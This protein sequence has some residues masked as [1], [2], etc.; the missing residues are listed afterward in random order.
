MNKLISLRQI[1][2][3]SKIGILDKIN[4]V[5]TKIDPADYLKTFNNNRILKQFLN[6]NLFPKNLNNIKIDRQ[7][8]FTD[9]F[10]SEFQW[11]TTKIL[12][13]IQDINK[14]SE[15]KDSFEL[16][17][18]KN[19]YK[20]ATK[21]N[22]EIVNT[23]G[24][25]LWSIE[26]ELHVA[27][28][29]I[30]P[31]ENWRKLSDYLKNIKNPFYEFCINASSK[32]IENSISFESFVN[33]I[34]NDINTINAD[35]L[36]K[37]FFVFNNFKL[38][39][40]NYAFS[41]LR[42]VLYMSNLFSLIDQYNILID[43]I[44]FNIGSKDIKYDNL[45]NSFAND[46]I[47]KGNF[48]SRVINIKN[49]LSKSDFKEN[50]NL[51]E[52]NLILEN[53]YD[54][55]FDSSLNQ[56]R[57]FIA[58][59]PLEFEIYEVYVKS[60]LNL[61]KD[62]ETVFS[63]STESIL[64]ELYHFLKFEKDNEKH[65]KKLIKFALKYS[66]STFG[67]QIMDF[68]SIV[69]NN[70]VESIRYAFYSNSYKI[71]LEKQVS[72]FSEKVDLFFSKFNY[73]SYKKILYGVKNDEYKKF[74]SKDELLKINAEVTY[75]YDN[76]NYNE[77]IKIIIDNYSSCIS[78]NYYKERFIYFLLN[79]YIKENNIEEALNLFGTIIFDETIFYV[80][81]N[82]KE[83]YEKTFKEDDKFYYIKN[84][85]SLILASLYKSEYNLYE[86][87]DEFLCWQDY[88]IKD[89]INIDFLKEDVL[90]YLL[91]KIC[92]IDTIKYYFAR[93]NDAEEFRLKILN[94]L[95]IFDEKDKKSYSAEIDQINKKI[96][97]RNVIKEV[98]NGRLFVDVD[99]LKEQLTEKYNDDFNRLLRIVGERKNN[100]L[101]G[102]N[103]SK[104]R[105]WETTSREQTHNDLNNFNEA[106]FIAFKNIYYEVRDQFLFS[107]EYGLDSSLSTRIRHGALENQIRSVFE[108]L[109]L[110]TTELSG[111][112]IDSEYWK[113]QNLDYENLQLVQKQIKI[114]SQSID[115]FTSNLKN[116]V[117]QINHE[118]INNEFAQFNYYTNDEILYKFYEQHL[119][120]LKDTN[121]IIEI[122][123]NDLSHFTKVNLCVNIFK[124]L[125]VDVYNSINIFVDDFKKNLPDTLPRNILLSE[126]LNTSLT[127]LQLCL[128]DISEWFIL[129]TSSTSTLLMLEDIINASVELT[130]QL[131][132]N[133]NINFEIDM[134]FKEVSAYSS[135]IY[136][137]NILFSN[138]IIHSEIA[139]DINLKVVIN[140]IED[141]YVKI[142]IINNHNISN[143]K[144][145][146][147][148][149]ENVK[150]TWNDFQKIERSNI[151]GESGFHK[152]KRIMIYEAK[153]IT[154][155]F[156]Y[157]FSDN[158]VTISL[159]LIYK[160]PENDED[161]NN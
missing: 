135:L 75:F 57:D 96:S 99:K 60:L 145:K 5:K 51:L 130:K 156:D 120:Y 56:S 126:K 154:E 4:F 91:H 129:E 140:L 127:T 15:L 119:E 9:D 122:L 73:Y 19:D 158:S 133:L 21:I 59:Y 71:P 148:N 24:Y 87:L 132:N 153:C 152:I 111:E 54:G 106:D 112:Y 68:L 13:N 62:F 88:E 74:K 61:K 125:N 28:E 102:F 45:F 90:I 8:N 76:E 43:V 146:I 77:V 149:L 143:I 2:N 142:D 36:V 6:N 78:V 94:F 1:L 40:Y 83:L 52:I 92:T 114:F 35:N 134:I 117:I 66:N 67:F 80:K 121:D 72:N 101:V 53:Y 65:A 95:I 138:S 118:N 42:S 89:I 46:L 155:K 33:Q 47:E 64:F 123:L 116:N 12:L 29:E 30:G 139:N 22:E 37:D 159:F 109:N 48:D 49:F 55:N 137:F 26:S 10:Q 110:V 17:L 113:S 160:K 108:N 70:K 31:R 16:F 58:N 161:I 39:N 27:E 150:S 18:L 34:Q 82:F 93:I 20:N 23:Y 98:N 44:I 124:Y 105:N 141:K 79:S 25:S 103:A 41:D 151:E 84:V 3:N 144:D 97:V 147:T 32:K 136:V 157:K 63:K 104:P 100:Y 7:V 11:I 107:K 86:I 69:D 85:N 115:E 38:A 128:E 14:F 131:Y 81:L 50:N